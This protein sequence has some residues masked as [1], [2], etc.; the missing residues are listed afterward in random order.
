MTLMSNNVTSA[1][2]DVVELTFEK[3]YALTLLP[4]VKKYYY[5][6]VGQY[7]PL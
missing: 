4:K 1:I 5:K 3:H 2:I 7:L 6:A